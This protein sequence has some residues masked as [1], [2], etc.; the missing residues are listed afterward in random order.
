MRQPPPQPL[1][2]KFP[3]AASGLRVLSQAGRSSRTVW[4]R[5]TVHEEDTQLRMYPPSHGVMTRATITRVPCDLTALF[6]I[7][8]M[9]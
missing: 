7:Q 1:Q 4:N 9:G 6:G 3:G 2:R 8:F 5:W